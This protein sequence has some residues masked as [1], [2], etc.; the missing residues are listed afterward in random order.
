MIWIQNN[1]KTVAT[2]GCVPDH[3][4]RKDFLENFSYGNISVTWENSFSRLQKILNCFD[5]SRQ[6]GPV[7]EIMGGWE[8]G[9]SNCPPSQQDSE[10]FRRSRKF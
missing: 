5:P 3:L 1:V 10:M 6:Y 9:G 4:K 7:A 2:I 8:V